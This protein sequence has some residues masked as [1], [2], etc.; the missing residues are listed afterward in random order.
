M[1]AKASPVKEAIDATQGRSMTRP[2]DTHRRHFFEPSRSRWTVLCL[3]AAGAVPAFAAIP[4]PQELKRL[5]LE[6]LMQVEVYSASRRREPT[7]TSPSAIFVLTN[8]DLRRARVTSVPEALRLVPGVQVGRVDA[9]KWAVSMRGFNS[10]EANKLLVLIDGR[11]IYDP[12]F[13]GVLWEAQDVMLEDVD[14][15]EVI[16]GAG[17]TLWGANA[18]NGVINIITRHSSDT[19]GGLA[20]V[21]AG[22]EQR[23]DAALRYGWEPT[24]GQAARVYV[25]ALERDTG[26]HPVFEPRDD[27]KSALGGF[28]WDI[29]SESSSRLRI[30]AELSSATAGIREDPNFSQDIEHDA[31]HLTLSWNHAFSGTNSLRVTGYYQSASY[32]SVNLDQDRDTWDLEVQQTVQIGSAHALVWG[33]GYRDMRDHV[34]SGFPGFIDILPVRRHDELVNLFVQDT[35]ALIPDTLHLVAGIKYEST[36]YADAEWLP[37]LRLS[38]TPDGRQTWWAAVSEAMRVPSRLEADLTFLGTIRIGDEFAAEKVRAYETGY[39]RLINDR[40]WIDAAAFYND[41]DELRTSEQNGT[42][43]NFMDGHT[44]GVEI[45][46]RLQPHEL[47]RIDAA[48]TYLRMSLDVDPIS[49]STEE[50]YVEG[51]SPR[52]GASLRNAIDL[53]NGLELDATLRYV[54]ELPALDY[55]SYTELDLA[56]T[57]KPIESLELSLIGQNLL[58]SHHPEQTLAFTATGIPSEVERSFFGRVIWRYRN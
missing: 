33:G 38:W 32:E 6:E 36:D 54:D 23:Y 42:L 55:P 50:R 31:G 7:Q 10:R 51:L 48:Y 1:G 12:L 40:V 53:P 58:D 14:R 30:S 24:Q 45:A 26:Y 3:A 37:N 43:R 13:S 35:I 8:E 57:W 49:T 47:W 44:Y 22:D 17:G 2:G 4:S 9:N 5:S 29:G 19:L 39:R 52:N 41:Y 21:T 28:R 27:S 18:F 11:T 16:R 56:V 34:R 46:L 20:S 15:I 25:K